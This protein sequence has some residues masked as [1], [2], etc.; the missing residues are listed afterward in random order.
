[1]L[2]SGFEEKWKSLK[3]AF[4]QTFVLS[5]CDLFLNTRHLK[6]KSSN[7]G[8]KPLNKIITNNGSRN[9]PCCASH[10]VFSRFFIFQCIAYGLTDNML[11]PFM[12]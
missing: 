5:M 8:H 6:V 12:P 3:T 9:K 1:M 7:V 11:F 10:I 2:V 4:F